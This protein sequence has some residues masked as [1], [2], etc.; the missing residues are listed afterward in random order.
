MA[1][2]DSSRFNTGLGGHYILKGHETPTSFAI[3]SGGG[4]PRGAL[5]AATVA[6][7]SRQVM[8]AKTFESRLSPGHLKAG[9]AVSEWARAGAL[10]QRFLLKH[11][12]PNRKPAER[13]GEARPSAAVDSRKPP[14][15]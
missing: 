6:Q 11:Q 12:S 8:P 1:H 13:L 3:V 2:S 7:E 14:E 15:A 4:W 10:R 9:A 5:C